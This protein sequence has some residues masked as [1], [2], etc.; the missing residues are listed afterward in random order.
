VTISTLARVFLGA[1]FV[2]ALGGT[3]FAEEA[4]K[5]WT[6]SGNYTADIIGVVSGGLEQDVR[7]LDNFGVQFSYNGGA[8]GLK[9]ITA[10][11]GILYNNKASIS[12]L[13]GDI[14]GI[15]NIE[16]GT[17]AL[18]PYEVW[19]AKTWGE[20]A[21]MLKAGLI[22]LNGTFDAPGVSTLFLNPS[23]GINATFAQTG[24]NGPS[25]FPT[26][27][28]A[29][30]GQAKIFDNV[31]IR[32]G[33]FD[34]IPGDP[35]R[36]E[37]TDLA[38]RESDG[39]LLVGEAEFSVEKA[40]FV[41]G[42][43]GYTQPTQALFYFSNDARNAGIYA[44]GEYAASDKFSYFL[45]AG[46]TDKKLNFVQ[47]YLGAGAVWTGPFDARKD[48]QL[49]LAI[50]H[51]RISSDIVNTGFAKAAETNVELTYAAPLN[52]RLTLQG[53]V[54]YV[55]NPAGAAFID[56]AVVLGMRVKFEFGS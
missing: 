45:R 50:A 15:S 38:W 11:A 44:T 6:Y 13:I 49:G 14:Q 27:G 43:W 4:P 5:T 2:A 16:T 21:A 41:A 40:R 9:G 56:H 7:Y 22:D 17:A 52:D 29:V 35:N 28:L 51:A 53:D 10:T 8:H 47:T 1:A 31:T 39:A 55:V 24:D 23:H 18:R 46:L 34:G 20:D 33:A 36:P 26:L 3:S 19:I 37:R 12:E 48:D 32:A 25:I 54:Q 30:V 42:A